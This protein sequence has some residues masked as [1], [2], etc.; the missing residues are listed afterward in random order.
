MDNTK[1][2][3]IIDALVRRIQELEQCTPG[4]TGSPR[5]VLEKLVRRDEVEWVP[6]PGDPLAQRTVR[7]K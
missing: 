4:T 1:R 3:I 2:D 5:A 7:L 6:S